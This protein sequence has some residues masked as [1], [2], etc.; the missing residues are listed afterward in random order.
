MSDAGDPDR[1]VGP[2]NRHCEERCDEEI[3]IQATCEIASLRVAVTE[4][5]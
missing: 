1:L 3:P 4:V 5:T 2:G